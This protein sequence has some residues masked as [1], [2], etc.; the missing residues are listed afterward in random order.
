M[1]IRKESMDEYDEVILENVLY[2]K[3]HKDLMDSFI[4]N[5]TAHYMNTLDSFRDPE[6]YQYPGY[7]DIQNHPEWQSAREEVIGFRK[8]DKF[9]IIFDHRTR[10][11]Y[12][13]IQHSVDD[14]KNED[15]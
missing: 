12:C 5:D 3:V 4:D 15:Y 6:T 11:H 8:Y 14:W 13:T 10:E 7:D 2:K 9:A 1:L